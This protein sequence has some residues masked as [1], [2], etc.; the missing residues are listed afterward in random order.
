VAARVAELE[1]VV[2]V[3]LA[4]RIEAALV[5][6]AGAVEDV[7]HRG[8]HHVLGVLHPVHAG[9]LVSVVGGDGQL[10]DA[11]PRVE[12]L[13]D[14]LGV[15]VEVVGVEREGDAAQGLD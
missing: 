10:E 14:D 13:E 3:A 7:A 5:E 12:Q 11:G 4:D 2:R 9:D 6:Q 1:I 15:E 8:E